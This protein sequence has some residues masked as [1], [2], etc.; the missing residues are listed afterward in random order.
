M[1]IHWTVKMSKVRLLSAVVLVTII[2]VIQ[3]YLPSVVQR[4]YSFSLERKT[5]NVSLENLTNIFEEISVELKSAKGKEILRSN[6]S[7]E[8]AQFENN[9]N[10]N[11]VKVE[12]NS[13]E[14]TKENFKSVERENKYKSGERTQMDI[15]STESVDKSKI[16]DENSSENDSLLDKDDATRCTPLDTVFCSFSTFRFSI[17]Y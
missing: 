16:N 3:F 9:L 15:N 6:K 14:K 13:N 11:V 7:H 5:E 10:G 17:L 1:T 12:K 2:F 8:Q 4:N